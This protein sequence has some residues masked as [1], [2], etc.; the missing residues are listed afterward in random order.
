MKNPLF[1]TDVFRRGSTA[2][3][4]LTTPIHRTSDYLNGFGLSGRAEC[5]QIDNRHFITFYIPVAKPLKNDSNL[6]VVPLDSTLPLR[7]PGSTI[8]SPAACLN[9][10]KYKSHH[11]SCGRDLL[12]CRKAEGAS[13]CVRRVSA[14]SNEHCLCSSNPCSEKLSLHLLRHPNL[15]P[16]IHACV[17][18]P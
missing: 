1:H 12:G 2:C 11:D 14:T 9:G 7:F 3:C 16:F 17:A 15:R 8:I 6:K 18:P 4:P 10:S 13:T 5:Q